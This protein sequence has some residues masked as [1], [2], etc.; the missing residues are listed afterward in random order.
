MAVPC[1]SNLLDV[2]LHDCLR[3][4][5]LF[6]RQSGMAGQRHLGREPE[7]GLTVRVCYVDVDALF[8]MLEEEQAE[9]AIADHSGCHAGNC[10][11]N[12][13]NRADSCLCSTPA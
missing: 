13:R 11:C 4:P 9:R 3:F 8:L 2:R 12:G 6:Y 5:Q 1:M 10:K 7:L